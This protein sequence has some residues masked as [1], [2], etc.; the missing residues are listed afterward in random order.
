MVS[1]ARDGTVRLWDV[2]A[3]KQLLHTWNISAYVAV[4]ELGIFPRSNVFQVFNPAGDKIYV[5]GQGG[6]ITEIDVDSFETSTVKMQDK[7]A[8]SANIGMSLT[9]I[10]LISYRLYQVFEQ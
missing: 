2:H 10:M 6:A 5:G 1:V 3:A 7:K 4:C 8:H 9:W